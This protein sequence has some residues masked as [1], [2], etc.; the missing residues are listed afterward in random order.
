MEKKLKV[1]LSTKVL[2]TW[3]LFIKKAVDLIHV[4][5]RI[6]KGEMIV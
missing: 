4:Q 2:L 5:F 1:H 3:N 6:M